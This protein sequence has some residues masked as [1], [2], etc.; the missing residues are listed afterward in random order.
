MGAGEAVDGGRTRRKEFSTDNLRTIA[1]VAAVIVGDAVIGAVA[2]VAVFHT[3]GQAQA[4][5]LASAFTAITGITTAYFGI[6]AVSNT[7]QRGLERAKE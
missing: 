5:F 2:L 1:G 4:A 3:D 7:A 6:K